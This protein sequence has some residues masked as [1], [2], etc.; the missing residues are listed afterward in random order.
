MFVN[1][2]G[3]LYF[4]SMYENRIMK[5]IKI[6]QKGGKGRQERAIEWVNSKYNICMYGSTTMKPLL[7]N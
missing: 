2:A 5:P 7:Y 4:I 3:L 6:D 1:K